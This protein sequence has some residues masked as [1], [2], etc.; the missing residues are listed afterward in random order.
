MK[1][2]VEKKFKN[3]DFFLRKHTNTSSTSINSIL[4]AAEVTYIL[5]S[6]PTNLTK[7]NKMGRAVTEKQV[8]EKIANIEVKTVDLVGKKHTLVAVKLANGFTIVETATCVDSAN[9]SEEIGKGVCMERIKN[10]IWLLEG[11]L[12]Q[13]DLYTKDNQ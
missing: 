8:L 6:N 2:A 13:E 3:M 11:Y 7:E 9:Y 12:L 10:K 1:F 4:K 5:K